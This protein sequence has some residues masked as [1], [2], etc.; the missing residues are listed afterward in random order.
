MAAEIRTIMIVSTAHVS[1]TTATVLNILA[2]AVR[3]FAP[4]YLRE[5]LEF[6]LEDYDRS[7]LANSAIL[8]LVENHMREPIPWIDGWCFAVPTEEELNAL[9]KSCEGFRCV[10]KPGESPVQLHDIL[11]MLERA[12]LLK[13]DYLH[14]DAD[15]PVVEGAA[16]YDW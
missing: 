11:Q 14:Y 8:D 12:R 10:T 4:C 3:Y 9:R 1:F 2:K 7:L 13:A 5:E 15:G 6:L 16:Q